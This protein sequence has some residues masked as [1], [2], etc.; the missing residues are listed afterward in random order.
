MAELPPGA[1]ESAASG[2]GSA[3]GRQGRATAVKPEGSS[4]HFLDEKLKEAQ[5]LLDYAIE[6]G[7]Q[8]D[9]AVYRDVVE[10]GRAAVDGWNADA[11]V[12]LLHATTILSKQMESVSAK[13]G[14]TAKKAIRPYQ[15][16]A[17]LFALIVILYSAVA[18]TTSALSTNIRA[19]LQIANPLAVKLTAELGPVESADR[20][21]CDDR[22]GPTS[23][24]Q[25]TQTRK[26]EGPPAAVSANKRL[27]VRAAS[28]SQKNPA[29]DAALHEGIHRKE[30]IEDLQKFATS[31]RA[32]YGDAQ[33][34]NR[35]YRIFVR[36]LKQPG[37]PFDGMQK[38]Q[39][40]L[41]KIF[42]LPP[43]LPDLARAATER[44]CV[45]QQVRYYAQLTE[46]EVTLFSGAF[47]TSILPVFYALLG[48][49]AYLLRQFEAQL[50]T[51]GATNY[52][53]NSAHFVTA[54]IAGA[55]VGLFNFGQDASVSPLAIAFL[56]GYAVDVFFTFLETLIRA[57]TRA[58][59]DS[60]EKGSASTP[61]Q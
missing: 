18:F 47:A 2:S 25:E 5:E 33:Q 30:I 29:N 12:R 27:G 21:L 8:I 59:G 4:A 1:N 15:L 10:A 53:T 39:V 7:T 44:I 11:A 17:A 50:R 28:P 24:A 14:K 51:H 23:A 22:V 58:R 13:R 56:A 32:M 54:T 9:E 46:E 45:Y 48:A 42:E 31:I 19:H 43:G 38:D 34:I 52:G 49:C 20:L 35:I 55:V 57:F 41:T 6:T 40:Q 16:V 26:I 61:K 3:D 37:D 36:F 60:P